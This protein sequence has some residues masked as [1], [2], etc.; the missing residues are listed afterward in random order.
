MVFLLVLTYIAFIG[1]GLANPLIGSAWPAM[2]EDL[3]VPIASAGL[4]QMMI[5]GGAI[6]SGFF[7]GKIIKH[8][9]F[10]RS[11]IV[12]SIAIAI[13]ILMMS[14]TTNFVLFCIWAIPLGLG[15]GLLDATLNSFAAIHY[16]AKHI[17]WMH[18]AWSIGGSI[19]PLIIS[20]ALTNWQSWN[21]GF[22]IVGTIQVGVFILSLISFPLWKKAPTITT[23]DAKDV[24]SN[25]SIREMLRLTGAKETFLA[26][27]SFGTI[28]AI[29][30]IWGSTYFV[31][32]H[33]VSAETAAGWI[34]LYF[35]GMTIGR[36]LAGLLAIKLIN[37]QLLQL[38][39]LFLCLGILLMLLPV[40]TT[41][42]LVGLFLAG[43]GCSP[44]FPCLIH[45]TPKH[46]GNT[47]SQ[48]IIGYQLA[49]ASFSMTVMPQLFGLLAD[50]TS[51]KLLPPV[52]AIFLLLL[53]YAIQRLYH[54]ITL[55][56]TT[57]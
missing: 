18:C 12:S 55:K 35:L 50:K 46:F 9:S 39:E 17:N 43:L 22:R 28:G 53:I 5:S 36:F 8:L 15:T 42:T 30:I 37:K 4:V 57:S 19:G 10:A 14:L 20:L 29:L 45:E 52:L 24:S 33:G 51:Y 1:M 41:V 44:M 54:K 56:E 23:E 32:I 34:S 48:H 25:L 7:A 21:I 6:G 3:G 16:K 27:F 47:Y 2:Y 13:P 11:V 49:F 26:F 40:S 31:T 38:G